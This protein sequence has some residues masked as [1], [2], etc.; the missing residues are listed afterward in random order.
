M[1]KQYDPFFH[2]HLVCREAT[3]DGRLL[4]IVHSTG[5]GHALRF[6]VYASYADPLP[7][8]AIVVGDGTSDGF[9]GEGARIISLP[10]SLVSD[11]LDDKEAEQV[12]AAEAA[13][14]RLLAYARG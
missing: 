5:S 7:E 2:T 10:A 3:F 8:A 12:W 9:D 11:F 4:S 6:W 14:A 1:G 13:D